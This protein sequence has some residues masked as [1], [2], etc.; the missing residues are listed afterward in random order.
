[1]SARR[2]LGQSTVETALLLL[3]VAAAL[4][5]FFSF[6]RSGVAGRLKAGSDTFGHGLLHDGN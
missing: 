4:V 5:L 2:R 6:I 1:M 3:V